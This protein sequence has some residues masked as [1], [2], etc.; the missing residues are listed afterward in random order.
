MTIVVNLDVMLAR[1]RTAS[2]PTPVQI[3]RAWVEAQ[4]EKLNE[5]LQRDPAGARRE[6]QKHV[7]DLRIAPAPE[8]GKKVVQV[9]G[10]AKL[11]GLLGSEEA[12][13]LQLVA[14]ARNHRYQRCSASRSI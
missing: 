9:T 10:R 8:A 5:L 4:I 6:I 14:G 7:E 11:D 3:D 12:V 1:L 2:A 13:R